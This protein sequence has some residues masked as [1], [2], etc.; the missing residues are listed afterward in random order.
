MRTIFWIA[1]EDFAISKYPSLIR[2]QILQGCSALSSISL[3]ANAT[4]HSRNSGEEFLE[5]I[6]E[7]IHTNVISAIKNCDMYS[8]LIDESTD[9][10]VCKQ[11]VTFARI[12]DSE[13]IPRTYFLKDIC[14]SNPKSDASVLFNELVDYLS[15]EGLSV[16]KMK[17]FGSDGA[18][19]MTGR[20]KGV[21]TRL[22]AKSP[23][24]IAIHCM[25]HKF[26][27]CT[28]Q[29][30]KDIPYLS[31]NFEKV[32]ADL[33]YYFG[34]SKSG[35]R[36]CEFEQIQ[37]QLGDTVTK[38]KEC[39]Q[40]RWIAFYEAVSAVHKTWQSLITYFK[41]HDDKTAKSFLRKLTDY[42]FVAV[43]YMLMD[44]LP[45][46]A[47]MSMLLQKRDLDLSAVKPALSDLISKIRAAEKGKTHYQRE[48]LETLV[49]TKDEKGNTKHISLKKHK[50]DCGTSLKETS[51]EV[52]AIR[53]KFCQA[54]AKNIEDRFPKEASTVATSFHILGLRGLSFMNEEDRSNYGNKELEIILQHYG[55]DNEVHGVV[56]TAMIDAAQC[57]SEW[58]LVKTLVLQQ[59][60]PRDSTKELWKLLYEFHRD[61]IPNMI[62]V[63]KLCLIMPYQTAECERGFSSQNLIKTSR[64][65]SIKEAHLNMLMTIKAE[66]GDV[67]N[68]DFIP[69]VKLWKLKKSRRCERLS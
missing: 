49:K 50:L 64:R 41:Q 47:T 17:G 19:V 1:K 25:A 5:C 12:V 34:G 8:V 38:I 27:L 18:A 7:V 33:Y 65:N 32:M 39:H 26:N 62:K 52:L 29:A 67:T 42:R 51:K 44:I 40:I 28:S 23:H 58:A 9:I 36:K 21:A 45:A 6:A 13:F 31:E 22:K 61:S 43:V 15:S 20:H 30:S 57:R 56:S 46:V 24:L 4:Y 53:E 66:G 59:K 63:A 35:N 14:I 11:M 10:S 48:L 2:L 54:M 69:V 37:K 68:F 3:G 55:S 16:D 60:Y